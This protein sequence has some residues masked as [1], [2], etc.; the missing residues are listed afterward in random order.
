MKRQRPDSDT[1]TEQ[2]PPP[3]V[4]EPATDDNKSGNNDVYCTEN[5]LTPHT[6]R[7][8]KLIQEGSRDHASM[9][10]LQLTQITA[11]SSPLVLWDVL[12]RLQQ[13]LVHPNW[14]TRHNASTAMQGVAKHLPPT[15]RRNFLE[16][17][18]EEQ[19]EGYLW[20]TLE[21]IQKEIT[22][23][24]E[25]GRL[26]WAYSES[27][28]DVQEEQYLRHF[29]ERQLMASR[30]GTYQT[31]SESDFVRRRIQ[32]QRRV[33]AQRV[34][35]SGLMQ[36][37]GSATHGCLADTI[38][39]EDLLLPPT[40]ASN[41]KLQSETKKKKKQPKK[42]KRSKQNT[43][44]E[45][46]DAPNYTMRA[47]LVME[48]KREQDSS[49]SAALSHDNPQS[50]LATELLYRVFDPSWYVRHGALMGM[51]ALLRAWHNRTSTTAKEVFGAW[52]QDILARCICVLV[53]DR[54][55]DYSGTTVATQ[56]SASGGVVAP[57]RETAGQLL[58]MVW[59]FAPSSVQEDTLKLLCQLAKMSDTDNG[60]VQGGIEKEET[61]NDWEIRHGA[62]LA[63]KYIAVVSTSSK[64]SSQVLDNLSF[65]PALSDVARNSLS[66]ES[67]DVQ[68]VAAQ[69]LTVLVSSSRLQQQHIAQEIFVPLWQALQRTRMVSSSI[70]DLMSLCSAILKHSA[71]SSP[72]SAFNLQSNMPMDKSRILDSFRG[73]L[74][75]DLMSVRTATLQSIASIVEPVWKSCLAATTCTGRLDLNLLASFDQL[76]GRLFD[77]FF[78]DP[79]SNT[80]TLP[81]ENPS[82]SKA[83]KKMSGELS[84]SPFDPEAAQDFY[85]HR[86]S[87]WCRLLDILHQ[88]RLQGNDGEAW[89]QNSTRSLILRY[90]GV[91]IS[92]NGAILGRLYQPDS[93]NFDLFPSHRRAAKALARLF[94][95]DQFQKE[96][97]SSEEQTV[98]LGRNEKHHSLLERTIQ[99]FL[100]S[101]W[102]T[103]CEA[104]CLLLCALADRTKMGTGDSTETYHDNLRQILVPCRQSTVVIIQRDAGV[105]A[106]L[107][108]ALECHEKGEKLR[109][110]SSFMQICDSSFVSGC[111]LSEGTASVASVIE[112]WKRAAQSKGADKEILDISTQE[113]STTVAAMRFYTTLVGS[114]IAAADGALPTQKVTPIVRPLMTSL[115]N[116][117]DVNRLD[118]ACEAMVALLSSSLASHSQEENSGP[119]ALTKAREKLLNNMCEV[120]AGTVVDNSEYK[121]FESV[122]QSI[123]EIMSRYFD[124]MKCV[125]PVWRRLEVLLD[126]TDDSEADDEDATQQV[127]ALN[128]LRVV[129]GK[130]VSHRNLTKHVSSTFLPPLVFLACRN[131]NE[132]VR[133][134][135]CSIVRSLC[136]VHPNTSLLALMP[137]IATHLDDRSNDSYRLASCK[138]LHDIVGVVGLSICP[139]VRQLLR[140][141][142][143]LMADPISS[144]SKMA[145]SIFASLVR[146]AP[147]VRPETSVAWDTQTTP[148][149]IKVHNA[150]SVMDHL[151]HGKPL[152]A[153]SLPGTVKEALAKNNISLRPYQM[154]GI[155]WLRFLQTVNLNGALCDSM[156]LGEFLNS[157]TITCPFSFLNTASLA[158]IISL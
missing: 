86:D 92:S 13:F 85:S 95:P 126:L 74:D 37:T 20:L 111:V 84:E 118:H 62:L 88:A 82:K 158:Y 52:P 7:L 154:E 135:S 137:N 31:E 100:E 78:F 108:L 17:V 119:T 71:G 4:V 122:I 58:A 139:F 87:A 73:F 42:R 114:S 36:A 112:F 157:R 151:I 72:N 39:S 38:T 117:P 21:N 22:V 130:L 98:R 76:L 50:L 94:R 47:L 53:L 145:N 129:C 121:A 67:D 104:S 28:E 55:G 54:F 51:L 133:V 93:G 15:S 2:K 11:Q 125:Q 75:H 116:E 5:L 141:V 146:V 113:V 43:E 29:D 77:I 70:L 89:F 46:D 138:L 109:N 59:Y 26:L 6:V 83:N 63:L 99:C 32:W 79:A 65:L 102:R 156:G 34:G 115:K 91:L 153:Y 25:K 35:L 131:K 134:Q 19:K 3:Q 120:L 18:L 80:N 136:R 16:H 33:L 8:L 66:D 110:D 90:F 60:G 142:M 149:S 152:P 45:E 96:S 123:V 105:A 1:K 124:T 27:D 148:N 14:Q 68:S 30:K 9:A 144:I 57:V 147:L 64:S 103:Q 140:R 97:H 132:V 41:T 40:I 61:K 23:I 12:G 24:L 81:G 44:K 128:L 49:E 69:T 10:A 150:D 143:S 101:P 107:C 155:A 127:K 106:P 48:M 56:E